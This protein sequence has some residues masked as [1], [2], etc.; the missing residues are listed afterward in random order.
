MRRLSAIAALV[1][2]T[3]GIAYAANETDVEERAVRWVN[4][5]ARDRAIRKDP[6]ASSEVLKEAKPGY[7]VRYVRKRVSPEGVATWYRLST[8]GFP[9]GWVVAEALSEKLPDPSPLRPLPVDKRDLGAYKS[10]AALTSAGRGLD[11]RAAQYAQKKESEGKI[12]FGRS[13]VQFR[14]IFNHVC[15][16]MRDVPHDGETPDATGKTHP[17]GMI[18]EK[19]TAD[20]RMTAGN[21]L[22]REIRK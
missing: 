5:G 12:S 9:E 2:V 3:A 22:A 1:V 18:N 14:T 8:P 13:T 15:R 20:G 17:S 11:A 19:K 16:I 10:T 21:D 6:D 7:R 4:T